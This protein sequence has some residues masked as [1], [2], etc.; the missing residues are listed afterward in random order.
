MNRCYKVV[1]KKQDELYSVVCY[2]LPSFRVQYAIGSR[3]TARNNSKLFAFSSI[4]DAISWSNS[5]IGSICGDSQ[6]CVVECGCDVHKNPPSF[7]PNL[8][9]SNYSKIKEFW[10]NKKYIDTCGWP[11]P[12]GTIMVNWVE[13]KEILFSFKKGVFA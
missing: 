7:I 10:S 1:S 5:M 9:L 4:E 12:K 2:Y 11:V 13:P 8:Y 3:T 6:L